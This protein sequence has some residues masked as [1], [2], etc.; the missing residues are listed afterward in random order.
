MTEFDPLAEK[1]DEILARDTEARKTQDDEDGTTGDPVEERAKQL[2]AEARAKLQ[3][4][5]AW[6]EMPKG[7]QDVY[8]YEARQELT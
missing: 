5:W 8:R 3:R 6:E 7:W 1:Q 4:D 2:W